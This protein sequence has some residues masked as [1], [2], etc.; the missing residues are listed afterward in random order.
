MTSMPMVCFTHK[1]GIVDA[2]GTN[3]NMKFRIGILLFPEAWLAR[4]VRQLKL[5]PLA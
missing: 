4:T 2:N 1:H 3:G 5:S